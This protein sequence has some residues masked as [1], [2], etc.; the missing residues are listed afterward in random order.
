MKI[1]KINRQSIGISGFTS[2]LSNYE[3]MPRELY[4][5]GQLPTSRKPTVA[6][7]GSR[8]P[9]AYGKEVTH[10]LAYELAKRGVVI[11]SG[12]AYGIDAIAHEAA[13][14]AGGT[15]MAV[16]A[17]GLH[18]VYPVAHTHLAERI[19]AQGGALISEQPLG[20]EAMKHH[21]LARNR[22][23]SGLADALIVSEATERS[24]TTSTVTHAMDQNI[25]DFAVPGPITSLLSAGPNRLIQ[26]GAHVVMGVQDILDIIAPQHTAQVQLAL[27]STPEEG[28]ILE[29]LRQG[30]ASTDE[31]AAVVAIPLP[32]LLR[33]LTH[34]EL[35][36]L[37][38]CEAG[39]WYARNH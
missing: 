10:T 21:F 16:L 12:L 8:K 15:T 38:R 6:I 31:L 35:D 7:V 34:M 14:E 18:R 20:A 9:T 2:I 29:A 28:A 26:D 25:P 4:I 3:G 17:N 33:T 11:L 39:K 36:G 22:I 32:E 19:I 30:A 23:V 1:G 37:V 13:L 5:A 27:G 24:G